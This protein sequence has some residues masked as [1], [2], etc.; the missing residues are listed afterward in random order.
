MPEKPQPALVLLAQ[1]PQDRLA[2]HDLLFVSGDA[3]LVQVRMA[4]RVIAQFETGRKPRLEQRDAAVHFSITIELGLVHEAHGGDF[5]LAQGREDPCVD[6]AQLGETRVRP[7]DRQVVHGDGEKP[8]GG[9]GGRLP[10][11]RPRKHREPREGDEGQAYDL[12][13]ESEHSVWVVIQARKGISH[14][15][16]A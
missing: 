12:E 3:D 15:Q 16:G 9:R 11:C 10:R 14:T 8:A 2:A 5:G 7:V 13:H 1:Q 6:P 4:V